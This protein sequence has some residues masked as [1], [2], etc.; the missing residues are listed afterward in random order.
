MTPSTLVEFYHQRKLNFS[1]YLQETR[2]EINKISNFRL[3]TA[4]TFLILFYFAFQ[5]QSLFF[6]L[7]I[8]IVLFAWLMQRHSKAF[9]RKIHF[10][11]LV[12]INDGE[13]KAQQGDFASFYSGQT[14]IDPK[15]AYAHDLD[16]F[17][18]G[19]LFQY[20]NRANTLAGRKQ[21]A[22]RL[23]EPLTT[24]SEIQTCQRSAKELSE[25]TNFR[26]D[27]QASGMEIAELDTDRAQLVEWLSHPKVLQSGIYRP[28]LMIVPPLT[29][30]GIL[31]SIFFPAFQ[32]VAILLILFQWGFLGFHFKK[33]TAFHA[34]ISNKKNIL[35][36]YSVLLH[37]VQGEKFSSPQ[38]LDFSKRA[39]EAHAHVEKLAS[40]VSALDARLNFMTSFVVNS[41][42]LYDLQCVYRLE[43]WKDLHAPKLESWIDLLAE[44]EVLASIGT[45]SF[46]HSDFSNPAIHETLEIT[47]TELGHPLIR[48]HERI[49]NPVTLTA[50]EQVWIVTGANMAG[51]STFLRTLGINVV[52]ALMGAP[53]CARDFK[54]PILGLRSGMRTADSLK[55]HESYFYAELNRLKSIIDEL[56]KDVPLLI[57]LDEILK[58]TNSNDKQSGSIALVKQLLPHPCLVVIATH[59]LVLGDLEKEYP[60]RIKNYC[61]EATIEND[62]LSFDYKLKPGLAQKMNATFLMRK[63]GII[64]R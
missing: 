27:F 43:Q 60:N 7:P 39:A 22:Q 57:L 35:E 24:A 23:K 50:Q 31:V 18:D 55:D 32:S 54:T 5:N 47:A 63:M 6:V 14:F 38:L 42:L 21:F 36:K 10:E 29:V 26:Q 8:P 17:G 45:F 25:K 28:L 62:Q 3:L 11:N 13:A 44:V 41:L 64:P 48:K 59:D 51:K 34:Y 46:N 15:H 9:T 1:A 40:L 52:L 4:A 37:Q 56:R 20:M 19:S 49:A 33:I 2:Q 12:A 53:V 58:G 61:F 30:L 16:L